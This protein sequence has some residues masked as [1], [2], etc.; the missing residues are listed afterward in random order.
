MSPA[1]FFRPFLFVCAAFALLNTASAQSIPP[2]SAQA[3][4]P[5]TAAQ[6]RP[7]DAQDANVRKAKALIDQ[8]IQALG[9]QAYL[10]LQDKKE[11]GRTYGFHSGRPTGAGALYWRFWKWPDKERIEL[12]KQR[13]WIIIH[14]GDQGNEITFRGIAPEPADAHAD[15]MRRLN[16]SLEWVLRK[17]LNEPGVALFY[18][19]PSVAAQKQA[20]QVSILNASNESVTIDIDYDSHLPIRKTFTWR[21]PAD[22]QKNEESEIYDNYKMV[23]GIATPLSVTRTHNGDM[24]NQRFLTSVTYNQSLA[25]AMFDPHAVKIGKH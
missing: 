18:D 3:V 16:Y 17:W 12:T 4:A 10:G 22:R 15:Y 5:A 9:G 23:Q 6:A 1:E 8:M 11:E 24:S 25:D 14:N 21:D 7:A 19:G 2:P 13:D 20:E